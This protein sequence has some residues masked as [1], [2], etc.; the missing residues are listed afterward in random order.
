[1]GEQVAGAAGYGWFDGVRA[2][3]AREDY[4]GRAVDI[5]ACAVDAPHQRNR[6]YWEGADPASRKT[7][8]SVQ[9]QMVAMARGGQTPNGSSAPSTTKRGAPNPAFPFW[10]MAWSDELISG[11]YAGIAISPVLAAE[12]IAAFLDAEAGDQNG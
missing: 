12:V 6:L 7:G 3:L 4:A 10:L 9:T 1:M 11:V 2:D 8:K 5:P